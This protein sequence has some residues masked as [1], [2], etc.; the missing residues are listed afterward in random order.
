MEDDME[1]LGT[2]A[3]KVRMA[4]DQTAVPTPPSLLT[5][6]LDQTTFSIVRHSHAMG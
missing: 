6:H 4:I 1:P 2:P 5:D 3:C